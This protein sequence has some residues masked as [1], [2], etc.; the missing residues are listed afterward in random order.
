V[1]RRI[2]LVPQSERSRTTTDVGM[3]A[4]LAVF[5]LVIF[6]I[7]LGYY[8][9]NGRLDTKQQDLADV[10]QQ[11]SQLQSQVS[12]L[13]QFAKLSDQVSKA[14]ATIQKIYAGRTLVATL[15]TDISQVVPDDTWFESLVL[16]TTDPVPATAAA[17]AVTPTQSQSTMTI[18]GNTYTFE[19]VAQ[20]L[21][22]L[23]LIP[24]L[25]DV[26][27]VS[28]GAPK[29][30]TDQTKDVKGFTMGA[31]VINDQPPQTPLPVIQA[32]VVAP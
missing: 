25:S 9:L 18:E 21:V 31:T 5:V 8:V 30:T 7:G 14:E 3:L 12:S 26:S 23:Q 10:Q 22:R 11:V 29:G 13:D 20:D 28:A 4:M 15:L 32:E 17:G 16:Q 27:L 1:G 2:N 6:A 24:L 19:G